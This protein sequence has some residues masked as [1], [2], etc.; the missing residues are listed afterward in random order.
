MAEGYEEVM[1]AA[2]GP[3][4]LLWCRV[5]LVLLLFGSNCCCLTVIQ[6]TGMRAVSALYSPELAEA[7]EPW[8]LVAVTVCVLL[9]LSLS[10]LGDIPAIAVLGVLME[11]AL[12]VYVVVLAVG[13]SAATPASS[14][15]SRRAC[16]RL[17]TTGAALD[18]MLL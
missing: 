15:E 11:V 18:R 3:G 17:T 8:L 9:P 1:L 12:V 5:A 10:S 7:L 6:E 13:A 4:A 14:S 16:G 2:G